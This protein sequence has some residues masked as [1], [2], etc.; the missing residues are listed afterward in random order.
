MMEHAELA[1]SV[2]PQLPPVT[3]KSAAFVPPKISVRFTG[4][5]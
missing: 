4:W 1:A 2:A 3:E 5:L